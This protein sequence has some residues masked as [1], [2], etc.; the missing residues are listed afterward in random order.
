MARAAR[1]SAVARILKENGFDPAPKRGD[2]SWGDFVRRHLKTLW[3]TDFFTKK[4]WTPRGLVEYYV[5]FFIHVG[6]RRVHIAGM[7]P[8]PDGPWMKQQA[9]NMC[10]VFQPFTRR[11]KKR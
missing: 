4:V 11:W 6:T 9:R 5:L 8:N 1:T 3:A 7:T 10:M 2:G